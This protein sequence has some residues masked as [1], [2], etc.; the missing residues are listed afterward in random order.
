MPSICLL[1]GFSSDYTIGHVCSTVNA[2]YAAHHD[3]AFICK[4]MVKVLALSVSL[5]SHGG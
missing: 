4:T 2:S 5:S 1:T 3:Y